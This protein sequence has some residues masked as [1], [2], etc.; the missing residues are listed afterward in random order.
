[1]DGYFPDGGD[2]F[3]RDRELIKHFE[4]SPSFDVYTIRIVLRG[5][6][7]HVEDQEALKLSATK[8]AE[9]TERM[10]LERMRADVRNNRATNR[11]MNLNRSVAV[12][13]EPEVVYLQDR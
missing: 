12:S 2:E 6:R 1:M 8:R 9:L 11:E 4:L 10:L 3:Q 5:L 13:G 7:I